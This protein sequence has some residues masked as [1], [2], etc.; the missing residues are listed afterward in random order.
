MV[1]VTVL[2]GDGLEDVP[3]V[4]VEGRRE[5]GERLEKRFEVCL[6]RKILRLDKYRERTNLGRYRRVTSSNSDLRVC[7]RRSDNIISG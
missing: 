3:E 7:P 1:G 4:L 2:A 5:E 6:T